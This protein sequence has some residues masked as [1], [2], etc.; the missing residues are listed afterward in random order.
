[1][2]LWD[3]ITKS[4]SSLWEKPKS[5]QE[6]PIVIQETPKSQEISRTMLDRARAYE[7]SGHT[8]SPG[9]EKYEAQKEKNRKEL[10]AKQAGFSDSH[11][12]E[13]Y[14]QNSEAYDKA[15]DLYLAK[16]GPN[17]GPKQE[18]LHAHNP[19]PDRPTEFP[20]HLQ[21]P[22]SHYSD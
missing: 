4:V 11:A 15:L 18:F 16:K 19:D 20:Q 10:A 7:E 5:L 22:N 13:V 17:P 6:D 3:T 1:M 21:A 2:G 8:K 9:Q 12:M 14:R